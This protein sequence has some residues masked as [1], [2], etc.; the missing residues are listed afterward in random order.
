MTAAEAASLRAKTRSSLISDAMSHGPYLWSGTDV[1]NALLWFEGSDG[2]GGGL[3]GPSAVDLLRPLLRSPGIFEPRPS[4]RPR[5]GTSDGGGGPIRPRPPLRE[6]LSGYAAAAGAEGA[7]K[8]GPAMNWLGQDLAEIA[9]ARAATAEVSALCGAALEGAFGRSAD[10]AREMERALS[11]ESSGDELRLLALDR[12]E[13]YFLSARTAIATAYASALY[14]RLS[15]PDGSCGDVCGAGRGHGEIG[16]EQQRLLE[17][18]RTLASSNDRIS[19]VRALLLLEPARRTDRTSTRKHSA[20]TP[21]LT[22]AMDETCSSDLC[23]EM[24]ESFLR[25]LTEGTDATPAL[26]SLPSPLLCAISQA[27]FPIASTYITYLIEGILKAYLDVPRI[28]AGEVLQSM[29]SPD[30]AEVVGADQS[31]ESTEALEAQLSRL[32]EVCATSDRLS[33][34]VF[35]TLSRRS[36]E[37]SSDNENYNK[38][39]NAIVWNSD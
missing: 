5:G 9:T 7:R 31:L 38:I 13:A 24:C 17:K 14:D 22:D 19:E 39:L 30:A 20:A 23:R 2:G 35:E 15:E 16:E 6:V 12:S 1:R 25:D 21:A 18:F 32:R 11:S 29:E 27:Y 26:K 8:A 34:L 33:D 10:A 28:L 3:E 37:N 36:G 4:K